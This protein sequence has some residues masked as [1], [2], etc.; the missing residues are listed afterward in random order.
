MSY[1]Y[2]KTNDK[3]IYAL[4]KG[5]N[6]I[7]DGT[8]DE[9]AKKTGKS[10]RNLKRLTWKSYN[11]WVEEQEVVF[12]RNFENRLALILLEDSKNIKKQFRYL[13]T[14]PEYIYKYI[15][16]YSKEKKLTRNQVILQCIEYALE[17]K[18]ENFFKEILIDKERK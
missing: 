11:E 7:M 15:L 12:D 13:T 9:I 8:L 10:K 16:S 18:E 5:N 17:H 4:Y 14:I 6:Y 1:Y 3:S 2:T